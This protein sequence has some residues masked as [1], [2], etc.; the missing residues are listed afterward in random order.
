MSVNMSLNINHINIASIVVPF[1]PSISIDEIIHIHLKNGIKCNKTM[2][3]F[4]IYRIEYNL[5]VAKYNLKLK[6]VS[7]FA[8]N[9]WKNEPEEVK[10]Y[11]RQ[12]AE[13]VKKTYKEK[14]PLCFI[15]SN[16]VYNTNDNHVPLDTSNPPLNKNQNFSSP[17]NRNQKFLD[18]NPPQNS[19]DSTCFNLPPSS[20]DQN[21]DQQN[22][23]IVSDNFKNECLTCLTMNEDEIMN[24]FS[25]DLIL[26]YKTIT[27]LTKR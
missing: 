2:N 13:E 23:P 25:E 5:I 24:H 20:T 14:R 19:L 10:I 8:R 15:H 4:M 6:D 7:K 9:S 3:P 1:P 22:Q 17:L 16:K 26:T 21:T 27:I 11:Y 18:A 12:M